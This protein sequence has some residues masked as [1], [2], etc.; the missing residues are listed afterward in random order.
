MEKLLNAREVIERTN[1]DRSVSK[2]DVNPRS[3]NVHIWQG[4]VSL[5]GCLPHSTHVARSR[6]EA[7]AFI[8]DYARDE[9]GRLP[10]DMSREF[11][12]SGEGCYYGK[13]YAY[14]LVSMTVRGLF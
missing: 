11:K 7:L 5:P 12:G 10:R 2:D 4:M 6:K 9:E 3:L 8:R 1:D 14:E 13:Q